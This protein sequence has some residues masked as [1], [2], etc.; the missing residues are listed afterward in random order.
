[1]ANKISCQL[2][3]FS[4]LVLL[5]CYFINI[6]TCEAA[7]HKILV[8]VDEVPI[9]DS[10]VFV[11]SDVEYQK[12]IAKNKR[13]PNAAELSDA[14]KNEK[15]KKMINKIK[16]I[17]KEKYIKEH[18]ITATIDEARAKYEALYPGLK[19]NPASVFE[20]E[21]A[22]FQNLYL[23][24]KE[25]NEHPGKEKDIFESKL[26]GQIQYEAWQSIRNYY[27]TPEKL[28]VFRKGIPKSIEDIYKSG[29]ISMRA[30]VIN[31]K[32]EESIAKDIVVSDEE[33]KKYYES[34]AIGKKE[35][36]AFDKV[37]AQLRR[38][39]LDIKRG[40][41]IKEWWRGQIKKT[42]IDIKDA[43]FKHVYKMIEDSMAEQK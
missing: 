2:Q 32:F 4:V 30:W 28:E 8:V 12:F 31:E 36:P 14:I 11:D 35:K 26:K 1:M 16:G 21:R 42:N 41:K 9:T 19:E 33:L 39:L 34:K 18:N 22:Y 3:R 43:N 7:E 13:E 20:R 24:L 6:L 10:D 29:E 40:P 23:A 38:E 15:N 17:M 5:F 25:V 37:K 27:N